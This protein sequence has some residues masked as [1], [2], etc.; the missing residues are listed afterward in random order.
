MIRILLCLLVCSFA[1]YA[2]QDTTLVYTS[3]FAK[4][5]LRA[6]WIAE[7]SKNGDYYQV[8][9]FDNKRVL[10]EVINFEDKN[11]SIRKGPYIRY[12]N[13]KEIEKGNFKAGHKDSVWKT[14]S[15][16]GQ[17]HFQTA[18]N[19]YAYAKM[20]GTQTYFWH[21]SQ[22]KETGAYNLGKK[23]G[24]WK[25]FYSDGK[26]AGVEEYNDE[27]K[28]IKGEYFDATGKPVS[29]ETLFSPPTF[30]GGLTEFYRYLSSTIKY[31]KEA[32]SRRIS[33]S[34]VLSLHVATTGKIKDIE[35]ISSPD[36]SLSDEA[37]R[38]MQMAPR[39]IPGKQFGEIVQTKYNIPIKFTLP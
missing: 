23:L 35:V 27:G 4:D 8:S 21:N 9:F 26:T 24:V 7:P 3:F 22:V 6:K 15:Y 16:D 31:P 14:Y 12:K 19:N 1:G 11:F 2:Q 18:E 17:K 39:W 30:E 33:G 37:V 5:P 20:H 32:L 10:Q 36:K 34:V 25:L 38:A 29:Y 28:K 13:G